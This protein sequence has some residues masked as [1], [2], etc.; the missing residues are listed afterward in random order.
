MEVLLIPDNDL[1]VLRSFDGRGNIALS[2]YLCLDTHQCRESAYNEF[3]QQMQARLAEHAS[4]PDVQD[5]LV[6]D[7]EI[8]GLYLRTNGHRRHAGVAIFSCAARLFWR[9]FPLIEA[10]P[11]KVT[12]GSRFDLEPLMSAVSQPA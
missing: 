6:E 3:M 7:M 12:V 2:A 4:Q 9:A 11:T 10:I 5:A 8:V 1:E